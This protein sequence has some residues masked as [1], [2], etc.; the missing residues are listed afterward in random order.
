MLYQWK[1]SIIDK[2]GEVLR[3]DDIIAPTASDADFIYKHNTQSWTHEELQVFHYFENRTTEKFGYKGVESIRF[4]NKIQI[5]CLGEVEVKLKTEIPQKNRVTV[6]LKSVKVSDTYTYVF[7]E[8]LTINGNLIQW[9]FGV[10]NRSIAIVEI[11]DDVVNVELASKPHLIFKG[12]VMEI[13]P[14]QI[15]FI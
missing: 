11:L 10:N 14:H 2:D 7:N 9:G 8:P 1:F 6:L 13:M 5:D 12:Q 4:N 15:R 3:V